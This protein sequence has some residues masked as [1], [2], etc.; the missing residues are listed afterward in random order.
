MESGRTP[1]GKTAVIRNRWLLLLLRVIV[2]GVFIWA[3]AL[4]IV[5]PLDFAQSIKNYQVVP[6]SLAFLAAVVLPWV[7][8]LSGAFL[9]IG[10]YRRS[11]ALIISLRLAGVIALVALALAR[12]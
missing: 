3:G 5:D 1:R 2:G 10:L 12:G 7:E 6:H 8:V 9:I 4:K 11:S